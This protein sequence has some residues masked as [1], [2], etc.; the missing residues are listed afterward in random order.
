MQTLR[1]GAQ[2]HRISGPALVASGC[3]GAVAGVV[4]LFA[5]CLINHASPARIAMTIAGGLLGPAT[6]HTGGSKVLGV[7]LQV[8]MGVIIALLF[9]PARQMAARR[10]GRPLIV[11]GGGVVTFV[12]MNYVVLP[13]S[14]WH[15]VPRFGLERGLLNLVAMLVFA[16]IIVYG[17]DALAQ[18]FGRARR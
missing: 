12:V 17:G 8:A 9:V 4:D 15:R 6:F 10:F 5:A 11:L 2:R 14:A 3:A 13:L 18:R 16:A 1:F 7:V